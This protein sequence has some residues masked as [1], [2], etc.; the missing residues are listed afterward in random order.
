M[1]KILSLLTI[2]MVVV[3][4]HHQDEL[5]KIQ[6]KGKTQRTYYSIIYYDRLKR[7]FT[8]QVDSILKE[9]DKS[10]SLWDSASIISRINR[11]DTA[12]RIDHYFRE[13]YEKAF[14]IAGKTNGAFDFTVGPLV[15]AW[16]FWRNL[17]VQLDSAKVDSLRKLVNFRAVS[18]RGDRLIKRD[19]GMQL[20]FNAI[21]QG[22]SVDLLASFL[23]S[24]GIRNFLV[25]IGGEVYAKGH[26][27]NRE[28][29]LVGIENPARDSTSRP[30]VNAQVRLHNMALSTSGSYRKYFEENGIRYSHTIDPATGYPVRHSL[31]SVSV[32]AHNCAIA[33]GYATAFMVMG[34]EKAKDFLEKHKEL[35]AY[36]IYS[37]NDGTYRVN[38]TKGFRKVIEE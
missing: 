35:E 29:W 10:V 26:K 9:V 8:F 21:A 2:L 15:N 5:E 1:K 18:I 23:E 11:N 12:A 13:I 22:Y 7:E 14:S 6:L 4:C 30:S 16:G 20:D 28:P 36:F 25:D 37:S 17:R 24:R 19:P 27:S 3:S 31:L 33:D 32:L 34:L 38:A